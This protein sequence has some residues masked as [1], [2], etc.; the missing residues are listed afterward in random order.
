MLSDITSSKKGNGNHGSKALENKDVLESAVMLELD[1]GDDKFSDIIASLP[2]IIETVDGSSS[3]FSSSSSI[4][5]TSSSNNSSSNSCSSSS[6]G[7]VLANELFQNKFTAPPISEE[8]FFSKEY[9]NNSTAA[10]SSASSIS[11]DNLK[12]S[13]KISH[14]FG[15]YSSSDDARHS[16]RCSCK[17]LLIGIGADEQ[18]AGYGRHR[19]TF[20]SHG[21]SALVKVRS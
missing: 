5:S 14:K 15:F 17:S 20:L 3:S 4:S 7:V 16:C 21:I 18:M 8:D 1:D 19:S 10:A 6:R 13:H 11:I 9:S 2:T 12:K